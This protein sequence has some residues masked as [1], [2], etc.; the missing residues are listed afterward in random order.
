MANAL[1]EEIFQT[2]TVSDGQGNQTELHSAIDRTEGEYLEALIRE[3][4]AKRVV[5]IGCAHGIS[6]LFICEALAAKADPEVVVIDPYQSTYFKGIGQANLDRAGFEFYRLVEQPSEIALP[7]LIKAGEIFD[8]AF[9]DGNHDLSYVLTDF[10]LLNRLVKPDGHI[11]FDDSDFPDVNWVIQLALSDF[12]YKVAGAVTAN[13]SKRSVRRRAAGLARAAARSVAHR[14]PKNR[15]RQI[16]APSILKADSSLT[17]DPHL[18]ALQ[19]IPNTPTQQEIKDILLVASVDQKE[20]GVSIAQTCQKY[21]VTQQSLEQW[22]AEYGD[23]EFEQTSWHKGA[24]A[25]SARKA[26]AE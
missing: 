21:G 4:G 13:T 9:I 24:F 7:E 14:F 19:K 17:D 26:P 12:S 1:L 11:V 25:T 23:V 15:M 5:E 20:R 8:L 16:F 10:L 22:Q 3:S 6:S 18:V 2:R